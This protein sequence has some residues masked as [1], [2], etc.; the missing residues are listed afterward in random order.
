[1]NPCW[2]YLLPILSFAVFPA[3]PSDANVK[4]TSSLTLEEHGIKLKILSRPEDNTLKIARFNNPIVKAMLRTGDEEVELN[5]VPETSYWI[6]QLPAGKAT[7]G[8]EVFVETMGR[9]YLA[10]KPLRVVADE[11]GAFKLHAHLATPV[12]THLRYEPQPHK[13]TLGYW[14][15]EEDYAEWLINVKKPGKYRIEI[16]QGCGKNQGG[17]EAAI[18]AGKEELTFKV[19]DTGHFQNF[20]RRKLG[21]IDLKAGEQTLQ[22]VALK[23][24][25]KAVMDVRLVELIPV[26]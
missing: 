18:R 1:M 10:G 7:K 2:K 12:G 17:S 21:S 3:L 8:T 15:N 13:N 23:K 24:A 4:H 20:E 14:T 9:P 16:L 22:L 25:N 6:I 11:N 26:N 5:L 19:K